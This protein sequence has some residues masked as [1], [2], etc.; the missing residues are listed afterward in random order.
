MGVLLVPFLLIL[1]FARIEVVQVAVTVSL[2]LII[3]LFGY[4]YW[5]SF[6]AI[7]NKLKVNALHFFLYL[8][9][10]ELLPLVLIYKVLINYFAGSL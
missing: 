8:C 2:G 10:V 4:R 5:V 3:L 7:R 6:I 9:A 1:S